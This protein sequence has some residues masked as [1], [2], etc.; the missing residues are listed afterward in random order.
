[1]YP[2]QAE[3]LSWALER[4]GA[5]A[6]VAS[7]PANVAYVTE[8]RSAIDPPLG[9]ARFAVFSRA[10]TALVVAA[11][12]A[13]AVVDD[14]IEV[15]HV[16]CHGRV[17][18]SFPDGTSGASSRVR[19][20]LAAG[21]PGPADA[22]AEALARIGLS[23]GRIAL[24]GGGLGWDAQRR[25]ADRL[26]AFEL[27]D[28][29][30]CFAT[31]RRVKSPYELERLA[32]ALRIAE[33]ALDVVIQGLA[34]GTTE[35]DAATV[36]ATEVVRRGGTPAC[37]LVAM[38]DRTWMPSAAPTDRALRPGGLVRLDVGCSYRG[39]AAS[40]ARTA[41]LGEPAT[42]AW[43]AYRALHAALEAAASAASPGARAGRVIASAIE[44]ARDAGLETADTWLDAGH[45][46]GIEW[47]EAPTL[48]TGEDAVLEPGEVLCLDLA[49]R[50][51]P[52]MGLAVRNTVLVAT[53]GARALN[54]SRDDLV[55]LD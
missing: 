43:D 5:V 37:V 35:R 41:V 16:V 14:G 1:M 49:H 17:A 6:L 29:D 39:Y 45:G 2:H 4:A 12:D 40:V 51:F 33:E 48:T 46:I 25:I 21:C 34:R 52:S 53:G 32:H 30:G 13:A 47:R 18:I 54:H 42:D 36:Y 7:A 3:R 50:R 38:G 27:V 31:A 15:D 22:V 8:F 11:A 23:S 10:G 19:D 9:G 55:V 28:G 26:A 20:I 24:D 44:A